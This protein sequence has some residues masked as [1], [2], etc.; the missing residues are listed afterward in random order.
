MTY[1]L[2]TKV[3]KQ[4]TKGCFMITSR[5]VMVVYVVVCVEGGGG[6]GLGLGGALAS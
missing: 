3:E 4:A 1:F 2:Q 5:I 6:V